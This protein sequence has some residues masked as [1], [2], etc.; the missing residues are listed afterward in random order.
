MTPFRIDSGEEVRQAH[1]ISP[2]NLLQRVPK[3][4]L[5]ANARLVVGENRI[6]S[7][8]ET[9][10]RLGLEFRFHTSR[11]CDW[12]RNRINGRRLGTARPFPLRRL[13]SGPQSSSFRSMSGNAP[14]T[15]E[16]S[17][18]DAM[19]TSVVTR[20]YRQINSRVATRNSSGTDFKSHRSPEG[21]PWFAN[22][23]SWSGSYS[24]HFSCRRLALP[25]SGCGKCKIGRVPE[26]R[27]RRRAK[28]G[29]SWES[30]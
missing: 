3:C 26:V 11:R 2:G 8:L 24:R 28:P 14:R 29:W 17:V 18:A 30:E 25:S 13:H 23:L 1:V 7:R 16:S 21:F 19:R 12:Q 4:I 5:E 9:S 20:N 27:N 22:I 6:A 15:P 10:F